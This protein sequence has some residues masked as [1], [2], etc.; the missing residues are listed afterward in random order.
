MDHVVVHPLHFGLCQVLGFNATSILGQP[1]IQVDPWI[2]KHFRQNVVLQSIRVIVRP[3]SPFP[4]ATLVC[5]EVVPVGMTCIKAVSMAVMM[6]RAIVP[7][8]WLSEVRTVG[9]RNLIRF[10]GVLNAV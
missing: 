7:S 1:R 3:I 8:V 9:Q 2:H 10:V 4:L 5:V 6:P